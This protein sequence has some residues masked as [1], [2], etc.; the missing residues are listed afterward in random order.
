MDEIIRIKNVSR[1]YHVGTREVPAL[2]G[3]DL[4]VQPGTLVTLRGRSGSGKTTLLNCIGGLDRPTSGEVW[5]NGR[6]IGRLSEAQRVNLRRHQIGFIFQSHAL[7]ATYSARENIDLM[8]RLAG[9]SWSQRKERVAEVLELVGLK[10]WMDHRPFEMSGGQQQRVAIARAI[11][12]RP[13]IIL[14]D[15]PTG[16]LDIATGGQILRLL[17]HIAQNEGATVLVAT[18][19]FAVDEFADEIYYLQDGRI[20]SEK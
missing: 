10:S 12:P 13:A 5:V 18:H 3:V 15:E 6:E 9:W 14:A 17:H 20:V 11:A 2:Q 8:L 1:V 4:S 7:L 19:D 16:E